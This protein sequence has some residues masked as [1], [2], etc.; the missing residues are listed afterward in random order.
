[1]TQAL[2]E[3]ATATPPALVEVACALCGCERRQL[4]FRATDVALYSCANCNL[5]Y[6]SPRRA[7]DALVREVYDAGYWKSS[8]AS[9]RGYSD[10]LACAAAYR[11][12][13]RRR[14]RVWSKHLP[15]SGRVLDVG[16]AA[17]FFLEEMRARGWNVYGCDASQAIVGAAR[18]RLASH[19][20]QIVCAPIEA[21]PF[22]D[23][24]FD[25]ISLW[26]VLEHLPEPVVALAQLRE[27]VAPGGRLILETQNIDSLA[28]RL[29]GPRWHHFKHDEHLHHFNKRTLDLVLEHAGWR[30]VA[31]ST[32]AAGKTIDLAFAAER[33]GRLSPLLARGLERVRARFN[34][35]FYINLLDELIVVAEPA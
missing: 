18:E 16:C 7:A 22:G 10:Y 15:A 30:R 26:D 5:T 9:E 29:L 1:L 13:Y 27:Q 20:E 21:R 25:L 23:Q 32:R 2:R 4:R 19:A 8:C 34:P 3:R 12:T 11:S 31:R 24:R 14:L 17:G 28:A 35:S 6:V 33:A